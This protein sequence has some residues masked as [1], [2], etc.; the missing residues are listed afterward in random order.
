MIKEL[1][2]YNELNIVKTAKAFEKYAKS[3]SIVILRNEDDPLPQLEASISV[4]KDLFKDLLDEI[5]DF[6]YQITL[7]VTL[8]K[9][10]ID[11]S[12]EHRTVY[13]NSS[14]K[15]VIK[16]KY[17]L[18]K[19]FQQVLHRIDYW[20]NEGSSKIESTDG[21]YINIAIYNPLSGSAYIELPDELKNPMKGLIHIKNDDK[22]FAWCHVRHLNQS[23][24]N[25]Q[26]ITK[27][28]KEFVDSLD[29]KNINFPV[30]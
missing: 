27:K 15:I 30:S 18:D 26:I 28:Y 8:T 19:S 25:L 24:K 21:K 3:Y 2:F 1:P 29:Y 9:E 7:K 17:G 5:K 14:T 20:I 11:G 6:K 16:N 23:N 12:I 22:C 13:F 10:K 4:I